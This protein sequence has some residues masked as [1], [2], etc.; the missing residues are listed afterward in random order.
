MEEQEQYRRLVER[1]INNTA[2]REE[3]EVFFNLL[4]KGVLDAYLQK[5]PLTEA[6]AGN[7]AVPK[8]K[9]FKSYSFLRYAV[10]ASVIFA[11]AVGI[12]LYK[13][14]VQ[15]AADE[16]KTTAYSI[17]VAM[18]GSKKALLTLSNGRTVPLNKT[19]QIIKEGE[20]TIIQESDKLIY[21][22]EKETGAVSYNTVTTPMGGEYQVVLSDGTAVWLNAGTSLRYPTSFKGA[23]RTVELEGEAYFEVATNKRQP[24][25]VRCGETDVNVIG[26]HFNV[27]AYKN[28]GYLKTTLAEGSV[29]IRKGGQEQKLK[30]GEGGITVSGSDKITVA[31]ANVEQDLAW[32]NGFFQ[33]DKTPL[34]LIMNQIGRWY[35]LDIRY[36]GKAFGKRFVGRIE[37]NTNLSA[38]LDILRLSDVHFS[39]A[40]KTLVVEE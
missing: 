30:P 32:K 39:M 4:E 38:V 29:I 20:R 12:F 8:V 15:K 24:F 9:T 28:E 21:R 36:A 3:L 2:S 18:P 23:E 27:M 6:G 10:A 13:S 16:S 33:F 5:I 26:T 31:A 11:V 35:D 1:Y 14:L 19:Q 22:P 25:I 37:R 17:P 40:G 34:P 7:A